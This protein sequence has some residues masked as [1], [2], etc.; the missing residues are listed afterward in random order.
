LFLALAAGALLYVVNEMF[1][2]GRRLNS[3]VL[4]A[5]GLLFGFLLAYATDLFL[6]YLAA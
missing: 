3:P 6:T 5:W 1:H 2:I 4:L